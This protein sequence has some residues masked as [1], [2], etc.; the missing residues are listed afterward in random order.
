[1]NVQK[2]FQA[3]VGRRRFL[4]NLGMMG[5]GA[6]V[7]ACTPPLRAGPSDNVDPAILNFALN[8]EY[9][10]AAFYLAAVGRL[11]LLPGNAEIVLPDGVANANP[12]A[13]FSASVRDFAEELAQDELDHVL[14]LRSALGDVAA[15]RPK[16]DFKNAFAAA[17]Q[18][19]FNLDSETATAF[20]PFAD[21]LLFLHGTFVFE[22][23]GV[24]AYNGAAPFITDSTGVL[25]PAAGILAVEA[26][27]SGSVRTRLYQRKDEETPFGIPVSTVVQGISDLRAAVGG[28]KDQGILQAS[29]RSVVRAGR[30]NVVAADTNGVAFARTPREVANI[31]FLDSSGT[32]L[33]GGFFPNGLSI[34]AGLEADFE[35]LLSL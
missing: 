34:P 17:A 9:L 1:M 4:N 35:F 23:V 26:Y 27:H 11:D 5:V 21:E 3:K 10:E 6:V 29:N 25:A 2:L 16:L 14:F 28:G 22:D 12:S 19:A 31:V 18:A 15:S 30:G 32:A 33:Q 7:A 20:D 13:N 24:T 8:L